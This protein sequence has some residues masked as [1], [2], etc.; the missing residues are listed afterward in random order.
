MGGFRAAV[1]ILT[2]H[3]ST[4]YDDMRGEEIAELDF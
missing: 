2:G 1:L 3:D 4:F